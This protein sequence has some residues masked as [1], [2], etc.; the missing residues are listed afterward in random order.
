MKI[1]SSFVS[2]SSSSSFI[3]DCDCIDNMDKTQKSFLENLF[4]FKLMSAKE[5]CEI[6]IGDT[7]DDYADEYD[8]E[9]DGAGEYSYWGTFTY[10]LAKAY[11]KGKKTYYKELGDIYTLF[12]EEIDEYY[13]NPELS[14]Y[15][16]EDVELADVYNRIYK[17]LEEK[18]IPYSKNN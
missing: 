4:G 17:Y 11:K 8:E 14:K 18:K 10:Y 9:T 16:Q 1:R 5:I 15:S 12:E 6:E 2:N 3:I 13:A 7:I